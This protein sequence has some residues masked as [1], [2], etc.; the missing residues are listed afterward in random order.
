MSFTDCVDPV[1]MEK[2]CGEMGSKYVK[3]L[4]CWHYRQPSKNCFEEFLNEWF[5][6]KEPF[7][8]ND[9][10]VQYDLLHGAECVCWP[11]TFALFELRDG[12][13]SDFE[14]ARAAKKIEKRRGK[15][16]QVILESLYL[17]VSQNDWVDHVLKVS[18]CHQKTLKW[19]VFPVLQVLHVLYWTELRIAQAFVSVAI[20]DFGQ[21]MTGQCLQPPSNTASICTGSSSWFNKRPGLMQANRW[22]CGLGTMMMQKEG[23]G[24]GTYAWRDCSQQD[25]TEFT[26]VL[27]QDGASNSQ[28]HSG[29]FGQCLVCLSWTRLQEPLWLCETWG[30]WL[31]QRWASSRWLNLRDL[32]W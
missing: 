5:F 23:M 2:G 12:L 28:F 22:N 26:N 4:W 10:N 18:F 21:K 6:S 13:M 31:L 16:I 27:H 19:E 24:H 3:R 30:S 1:G 20:R 17:P 11:E 25:F 15:Q 7:I 9:F 8:W 29:C 14:A 32:Q